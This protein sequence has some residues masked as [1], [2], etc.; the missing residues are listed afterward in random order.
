MRGLFPV[1]ECVGA[2]VAT[3]TDAAADKACPKVQLRLTGATFSRFFIFTGELTAFAKFVLCVSADG[4]AAAF[5]LLETRAM[6][7]ML[8]YDC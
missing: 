3:A 5:P 2:I 8:T 1:F 4:A 6:E 7:H